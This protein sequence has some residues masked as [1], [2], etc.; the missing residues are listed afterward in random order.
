MFHQKHE[1]S[2]DFASLTLMCENWYNVPNFHH[3]EFAVPITVS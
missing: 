3:P 1:N 2:I